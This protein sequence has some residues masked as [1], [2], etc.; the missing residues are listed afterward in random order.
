MAF[1][2]SQQDAAEDQG[3]P[4]QPGGGGAAGGPPQGGG[5]ILAALA[6]RQRGPQVSAPGP[7]DAANSMQ[8]LMTAIGMIQQALPGLDPGTPLHQDALRA[9]TRLSRHVP[10]GGPTAGV[11]RTHL[12]GLLQ[13][14]IKNA[15]LSRI[16]Q[17]QQPQAGQNPNGPT[18]PSPL[19][20]AASPSPMPSTPLPGA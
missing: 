4:P 14:V 17:Q 1:L 2:D 11:Q 9:V 5:P 18:G 7:G 3:P 15:L 8:M 19:P 16:M 12:Q 13:N 6:N 10:Q 20:G